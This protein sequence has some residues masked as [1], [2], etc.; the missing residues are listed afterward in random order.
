M[1]LEGQ[2]E[3]RVLSVIRTNVTDEG[4]KKLQKALPKCTIVRLEGRP[5]VF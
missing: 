3:L 5:F 1:K 4:A 2:K